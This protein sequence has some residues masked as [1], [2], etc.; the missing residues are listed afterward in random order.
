MAMDLAEIRALYERERAQFEASRRVMSMDEYL[1]MFAAEPQRHGRDVATWLRDLFDHYGSTTVQRPYG[2]HTRWKLFDLPWEDESGRRDGAHRARAAAAR[3]VPRG[4]ELL[5]HRSGQPPGAPARPQR[6]RQVDLR[7]LPAARDGGLLRAADE[8]ALYRFNWV[9]PKARG[10]DGTRIGFGGLTGG[11][12][13]PKPGESYAHLDESAIDAKVPCEV[14]DHPLLALP[15][16]GASGLSHALLRG[17]R[18]G[19][20]RVAVEGLAVAQVSA[21]LRRAVHRV[22]GRPAKVLAHVQVERWYVSRRYRQ[23]AVT[24]GPA[25]GGRRQGAAGHG[26][27]A[28]SPRCRPRCRTSRSSSPTASSSTPRGG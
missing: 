6:Q 13:G 18:R 26:R 20:A 7:E 25:D 4:G 9:F 17:P 2:R 28:R 3:G 14:R 19:R 22:P 11:E 21:H 5:A 16:H 12:G 10:R 8:G 1:A 24:L 27:R 23:G 15:A